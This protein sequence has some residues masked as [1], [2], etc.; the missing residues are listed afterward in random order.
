MT[1]LKREEK[2]AMVRLGAVLEKLH[3]MASDPGTPE[4]DAVKAA[5]ELGNTVLRHMDKIILSLK[6]AYG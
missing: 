1:L 5:A 4:E 2:M 6:N 3:E